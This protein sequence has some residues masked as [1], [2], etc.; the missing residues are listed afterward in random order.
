MLKCQQLLAILD[1]HKY[2]KYQEFQL[3]L[4]SDKPRML[5]FFAA[6]KKKSFITSG[7]EYHLSKEGFKSYKFVD[8][9]SI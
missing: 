1:A 2:K 5:F 9:V 4:G 7:P 6:H 8:I 3:L